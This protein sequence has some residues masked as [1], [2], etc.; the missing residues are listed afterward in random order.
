[1]LITINQLV[2]KPGFLFL[3]Q[4]NDFSSPNSTAL[5]VIILSFKILKY[6]F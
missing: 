3:Q 2:S 4:G 6:Y 5:I 1:M